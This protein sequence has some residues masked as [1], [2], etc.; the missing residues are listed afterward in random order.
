MSCSASEKK[1]SVGSSVCSRS[2]FRSSSYASP[3]ESA[4]WK[5]VGFDVTPVTASSS[6]IRF[7]SPVSTSSRE[8]VSNQIDWP[9][10][11]SSC[12]RDFAIALHLL[13]HRGN[14]LEA[15]DVPRASVEP[16]AEER[17]HELPGEGGADHLGA[18]AEHVHVVVLDALVG[19]VGVV[20]D[21]RPDPCLLARGDG[22]ADA[23]PADEHGPLGVAALNRLADLARLV[24]VVEANR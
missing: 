1:I 10:A 15:R 7:S 11:A 14:L 18:E 8:S 6:I 13:L 12:R 24:R 20:A 2:F 3:E 9:R 19:A 23:G 22:G 21:R 17:G 5:I 16:R 4:F